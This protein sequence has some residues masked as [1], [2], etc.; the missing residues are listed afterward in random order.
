MMNVLIAGFTL[1]LV[2]FDAF[3]QAPDR[4]P[5]DHALLGAYAW[6]IG[7]SLLGGFASFYRRVKSGETKWVNLSELVGELAT[8]AVAGLITFWLCKSAGLGEWTTAAFVGIAGHMGSR[9]LFVFE[10]IL[11]QWAAKFTNGKV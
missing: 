9:A 6:I 5:F 10:K 8:S 4:G 11:E 1:A 2:A 3:A 7:V